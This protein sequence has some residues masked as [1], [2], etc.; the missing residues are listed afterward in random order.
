MS[1]NVKLCLLLEMKFGLTLSNIYS[2]SQHF[3]IL[4]ECN[5]NFNVS[6]R[7]ILKIH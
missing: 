4:R 7:H 2:I 1:G 5:T 6:L 3:N